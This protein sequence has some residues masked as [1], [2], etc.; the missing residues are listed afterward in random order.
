MKLPDIFA[1][2]VDHEAYGDRCSFRASYEAFHCH[3]RDLYA[4]PS[5][6]PPVLC[7]QVIFR[8]STEMFLPE[9]FCAMILT[10]HFAVI[11]LVYEL[12]ACANPKSS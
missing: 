11:N 5:P 12:L 1:V 6:S 3:E 10:Y 8:K 2:L 9:H 7:P 4:F